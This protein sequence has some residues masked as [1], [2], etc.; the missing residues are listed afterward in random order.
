MKTFL[1]V[2]GLS[3]ILGSFAQTSNLKNENSFSNCKSIIDSLTKAGY[4]SK[5]LQVDL[6]DTPTLANI[7]MANLE[8]LYSGG[9]GYIVKSNQ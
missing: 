8:I 2:L 6:K 4:F 9:E 5:A 3:F 1:L 7:T